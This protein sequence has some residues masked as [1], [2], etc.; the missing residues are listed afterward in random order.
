[1][2]TDQQRSFVP[3][4]R[5]TAGLRRAAGFWTTAGVAVGLL[6]V[7]WG[8]LE[9][10]DAGDVLREGG[11]QRIA[12]HAARGVGHGPPLPMP[13]P[14][15]RATWPAAGLRSAI[16]RSPVTTISTATVAAGGNM[17]GSRLD[18]EVQD[19]R[20][21]TSLV[22]AGDLDAHTATELEAALDGVDPEVTRVVLDLGGL[23]FIDSAGL[24]V[25]IRHDQQRPGSLVLTNMN[26]RILKV[27]EYA[28]LVGHL[29][30]E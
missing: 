11:R 19:G 28:G 9:A 4:A 21:Q 22:L 10:A 20:P 3:R 8:I 5:R 15:D 30:I 24:G 29:T 23:E 2:S 6:L 12:G 7:W 1:M 16:H 13:R 27:L 18:V 17:P 25:L 14:I 26:D